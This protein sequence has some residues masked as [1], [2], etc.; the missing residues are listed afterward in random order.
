MENAGVGMVRRFLTLKTLERRLPSDILPTDGEEMEELLHKELG[1]IVSWAMQM[2][3]AEVRAILQSKDSGGLLKDASNSIAAQLDATRDFIDSCLVPCDSLTIPNVRNAFQA[4][5]LFCNA[6]RY[7]CCNEGNFRNRLK[8]ALPHL[9]Q[10]RRAMPGSNSNRKIPAFFFGFQ[11]R[12]GLWHEEEA[13]AKDSLNEYLD[14]MSEI[15]GQSR[16]ANCAWNLEA[17]IVGGA[18]HEGLGYL[19][20]PLLMDG[21]LAVL[22]EHTPEVPSYDKLVDAGYI[23][24]LSLTQC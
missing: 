7:K 14:R 21:Q 1:N 5:Q 10:N 15:R 24:P 23:E 19:V 20:K 11:L 3:E 12:P 8:Q 2:P 6:K 13:T 17:S 22:N 9:Y 4:Y 16:T 18:R